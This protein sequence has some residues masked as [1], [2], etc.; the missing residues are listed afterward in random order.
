MSENITDD[1]D[2]PDVFTV[3]KILDQRQSNG[4][5]QY[6][7]KWQNYPDE[8]NTW[9]MA[10]SLDCFTLI[11]SFKKLRLKR[12]LLL[13]Q[14]YE[15]KAKRLK[16][17]PCLVLDN[18]FNY[19]FRA[20]AILKAFKSSGEVSFVIRFFELDQPQIV[21]SGIAYAEIPQMVLHFYEKHC[22]FGSNFKTRA[23]LRNYL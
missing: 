8:D 1:E 12:G 11:N 7:V 17:D 19:D 3:E 5:V 13:N 14:E 16:L 18:P 2:I 20:Q 22:N 10:T 6:F 9:E 4:Q 23:D 15:R 21:P